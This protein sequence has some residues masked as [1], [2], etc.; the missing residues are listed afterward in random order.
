MAGTQD[1]GLLYLDSRL[2]N[3]R[4][5]I[6]WEKEI[7][8]PIMDSMGV[9]Q[10]GCASDRIYRLENS[11]QLQTAQQSEL[12]V[13]L[14]MVVTSS[15][16]VVPMVLSAVGQSDDVALLSTSL[17]SLKALLQLTKIYCEDLLHPTKALLRL[18]SSLAPP[19]L[20]PGWPWLT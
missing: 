5:Y 14:G 6:E 4:T 19:C 3:R 20:P 1:E 9:E 8:G 15:G 10:S 7:L 18:S 13:D 17:S 16:G 12:G 2:R 11:E